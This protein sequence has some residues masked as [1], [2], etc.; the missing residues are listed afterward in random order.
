MLVTVNQLRVIFY[1]YL[2]SVVY[3]E[4]DFVGLEHFARIN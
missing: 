2:Y 1:Y 4:V 3:N